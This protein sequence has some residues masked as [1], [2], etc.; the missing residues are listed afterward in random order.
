MSNER[1]PLK[2]YNDA[3]A[4]AKI[5][6][7]IQRILTEGINNNWSVMDVMFSINREVDLI[8]DEVNLYNKKAREKIVRRELGFDDT[9]ILT[10]KHYATVFNPFGNMPQD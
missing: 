4:E 5:L 9:V 1:Y 2:S 7:K 8:K 3:F 6:L 10:R